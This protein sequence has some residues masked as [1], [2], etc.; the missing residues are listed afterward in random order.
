MADHADT[1]WDQA[2]GEL[3]ADSANQVRI[4]ELGL[5]MVPADEDMAALGIHPT[6]Q[7]ADVH[8]SRPCRRQHPP[9]LSSP[10]RVDRHHMEPTTGRRKV[11]WDA[12]AV[13]VP[14]STRTYLSGRGSGRL[15]SARNS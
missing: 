13:R 7:W 9:P 1:D 2:M 6:K 12:T 15:L 14:S 3:L 11:L 4:M 10:H 8:V 5:A